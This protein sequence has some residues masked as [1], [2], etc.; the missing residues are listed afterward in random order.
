MPIFQ[1]VEDLAI[2]FSKKNNR[3]TDKKHKSESEGELQEEIM[4]I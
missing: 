4:K 1:I 2:H 3:K